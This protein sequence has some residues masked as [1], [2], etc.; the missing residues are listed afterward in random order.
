VRFGSHLYLRTTHDGFHAAWP[1]EM[2]FDIDSDPHQ[3]SDLAQTE[4]TV[5]NQGKAI[6]LDW[7]ATQLERALDPKRDPL[8]IVMGEGGPY[9]VRGH[10]KE[11]LRRL[12]DTGRSQWVQPS[13][14]RHGGAEQWHGSK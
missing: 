9:H 14:A 13:L 6:L 5:L 8:D 12:E 4:L 1:E 7:T 3:Q 2:L 10:L 11:Y